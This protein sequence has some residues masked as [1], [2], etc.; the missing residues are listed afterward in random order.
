[1]AE[2]SFLKLHCPS[3]NRYYGATI[4]K[5]ARGRWEVTDVVPMTET[6]AKPLVSMVEQDYFETRSTLLPCQYEST[7][8]I[9][10]CGRVPCPG[11]K[12]TVFQ[13][14]Y[15][16]KLEV[17]YDNDLSG[18][19]LREGETLKLAQGQEVKIAV[20]GKNLEAIEVNVGWDPAR[21]GPNMDID[22]SVVLFSSQGSSEELIYFG[23]KDDYSGAIHHHGDDL[24]GT[25][26][27]DVDEI[28]DVNL[29]RL[30]R[31][32][33]RIAVIINIFSAESRNQTFGSVSNLFMRIV[34]P[35]TKRPLCD[36]QVNHN[37]RNDHG[38]IIGVFSRSGSGWKFKAAGNASRPSSVD[39]LADTAKRLYR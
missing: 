14:V 7:R 3:K 32:Y 36:Y 4:E 23:N 1:M 38:I 29:A 27:S 30:P 12:Q 20:G 37:I 15:C 11:P 2:K 34:D 13:C 5:N 9:C 22:S 39:D 16:N 28:I 8:R 25:S 6:E 26:S 17:S 21:G 35:R 10:S 31:N 19:G 24:Y 18:T 33:D